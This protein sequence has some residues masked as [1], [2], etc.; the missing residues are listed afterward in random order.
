MNCLILKSSP[1]G[2]NAGSS[3]L[4]DAFAQGLNE[5]GAEVSEV[6]L[7]EK[8]IRHCTGCYTCWTKTPGICSLKDDMRELLKM[9][10]TSDLVVYA[11]PLY[12][13]SVP[14]LLKDF[15]DRK[16]PLLSPALV[17]QGDRTVHHQRSAHA[18]KYALISTAGFPEKS[19]FDNL[20]RVFEMEIPEPEK[21]FAGKILI[22]GAEPLY[23]DRSPGAFDELLD[24]VRKA[25]RE[26]ALKGRI[27]AETDRNI[28]EYQRQRI[29]DKER[30][31][32]G[33]NQYWE[34]KQPEDSVPAAALATGSER[35]AHSGKEC[36]LSAG[37]M[38]TLMA[39]MALSYNPEAKPG[40]NAIMQ[41]DFSG[42]KYFLEVLDGTCKAFKGNHPKPVFTVSCKPKVWE[43]ISS[44][45]LAGTDAF[46]QGKYRVDGDFSLFMEMNT[47]FSSS[48]DKTAKENPTSASN[49]LYITEDVNELQRGPLKLSGGM[50]LTVAFV[51]WM[52]AWIGSAVSDSWWISSAMLIA[53]ALIVI[54]R[55]VTGKAAFFETGTLAFA[56]IQV[57]IYGFGRRDIIVELPIIQYFYLSLL[58]TASFIR[59]RCLTAEYSG[60]DFPKSV[61]THPSF[62][63][64]NRILTAAWSV[65]YGISGV[66]LFYAETVTSPVILEITPFILLAPMLIFTS[67]F[68]KWY[69]KRF[70]RKAHNT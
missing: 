42:K 40:L 48:N 51:P 28:D 43:A 68:Q 47:M 5:A 38:E 17:E 20:V 1:R 54:Y 8:D 70:F 57:L 26:T 41:F 22:A 23:L 7:K 15:M 30:F 16:L 33:A 50:W 44:G 35:I 13:F 9:Y 49:D 56:V 18:R 29:G 67:W 21:N 55:S 37:G 53:A 65:Y 24:L 14:G 19:V 36:S 39:G 31:N 34:S 60:L 46:L 11:T 64:T 32:S 25:G 63:D 58:W 69:P 52:I 61:W 59:R 27:T 66:I 4:A 12:Y 6:I 45:S 10:S 62:T 2:K 3:R